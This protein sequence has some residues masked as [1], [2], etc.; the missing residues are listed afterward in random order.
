LGN[1]D[2]VLQGANITVDAPGVSVA[3]SASAALIAE[4]VA[5]LG[6]HRA[7]DRAD[8]VMSSAVPPAV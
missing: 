7:W 2:A 4:L 6:L 5:A 8:L 1:G 3:A